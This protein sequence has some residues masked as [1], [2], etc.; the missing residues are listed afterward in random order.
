MILEDDYPGWEMIYQALY[1]GT[2]MK[3]GKEK[4]FFWN[5]YNHELRDDYQLKT[6][7][8]LILPGSGHSA[9]EENNDWLDKLK[10]FV[11]K[12]WVEYPHIKIV[13]GCFGSQ[14][15]AHCLGGKVEKMKLT[16]ERP[17]ILGRELIKMT[18]DFYNLGWVKR[19]LKKNNLT[20]ENIPPIVLQ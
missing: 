1:M 13:G 10:D 4:W 3:D 14:V 16:K 6:M 20:K 2:L 7:K 18:D 11:K 17:K 15:L 5:A 12:V 9:Y 19:F 8:V